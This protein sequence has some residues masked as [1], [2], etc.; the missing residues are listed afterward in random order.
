MTFTL[1][2]DTDNAAFHDDDVSHPGVELARIL[3]VIADD[4][5]SAEPSEYRQFQTIRDI[6]GNDVGRYALKEPGQ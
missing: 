3:R 5:E 4:I 2:I 1:K 6:N